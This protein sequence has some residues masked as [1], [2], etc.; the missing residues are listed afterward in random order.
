MHVITQCKS[1]MT[2]STCLQQILRWSFHVD[3]DVVLTGHVSSVGVPNAW[4]ILLSWS[5]SESPGRKG[6]YKYQFNSLIKQSATTAPQRVLNS[7]YFIHFNGIKSPL[8]SML[9]LVYFCIIL[10][11]QLDRYTFNLNLIFTYILQQNSSVS[12]LYSII[13]D[14][15]ILTLS[16]NSAKIQPMAHRSTPV[17]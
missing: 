7:K 12:S 8:H 13:N 10:L 4:N 2:W 16:N 6:V 15:D 1:L 5:R 14:L 17:P 9:L 3:V 11:R